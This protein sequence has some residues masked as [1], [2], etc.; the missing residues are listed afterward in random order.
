VAT[1]AVDYFKSV[2]SKRHPALTCST[3]NETDNPAAI[4]ENIINK[5]PKFPLEFLIKIKL[6]GK[7][8]II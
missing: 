3:E 1:L 6:I 4:I 7:F 8:V 2:I 5:L